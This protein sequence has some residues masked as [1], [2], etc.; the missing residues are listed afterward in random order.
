MLQSCLVSH[1][2]S[3]FCST[4]PNNSKVKFFLR[5]QVLLDQNYFP[6]NYEKDKMHLFHLIFDAIYILH[7]RFI[8]YQKKINKQETNNRQILTIYCK[9]HFF[10]YSTSQKERVKK[11]ISAISIIRHGTKIFI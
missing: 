10:S 3:P 6:L 9:K 7:R 5:M 2:D 1:T 4:T 8:Y 11:E